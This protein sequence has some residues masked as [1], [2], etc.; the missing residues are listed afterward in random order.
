MKLS[1][2][3][4]YKIG[5]FGLGKTGTSVFKALQNNCYSLI[6]FDDKIENQEAFAEK[7][8]NSFVVNLDNPLW[9]KLDKIIISP[10]VQH[11]H[12]IFEIAQKNRITISSDIELFL[13]NNSDSEFILITGT[14]GKSTVTALTGHILAYNQANYIVG[15]NIGVPVFDLPQGAEGYILELSSFQLDLLG[16]INPKISAILNIT[17]DHIDR[18][19]SLEEYIRVKRKILAHDNLKIIGIDNDKTRNIYNTTKEHEYSKVLGFSATEKNTD[20][21]TCTENIIIDNFFE[22]QEFKY[23]NVSSLKGQHNRENIA[24]SYAICRALGIMPE[25]IIRGIETFPGLPHRLQYVKSIGSVNFYNDSKA[26]NSNACRFSLAALENIYWIVGGVYK[27]QEL[28]LENELNNVKKAYIYGQDK[29]IFAKY[30]DN[31]LDYVILD[32]LE[33]CLIEAYKDAKNAANNNATKQTNNILLAP[34]CASYDQFD[35]FEARG[36]KFIELVN[37]IK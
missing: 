25:D 9:Q 33:S 36:N 20:I 11:E 13:Q 7:Y 4:N 5:I 35:N 6:C 30:L 14:N 21:I 28:N 34:A 32:D 10:G 37:N 26:T 29:D 22:K 3:K 8:S 18:H 16:T 1:Q 12:K 27:E 31:K 15:G 23:Q 24:T 17:P 19:G 2:Y